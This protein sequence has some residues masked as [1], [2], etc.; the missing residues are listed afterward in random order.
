MKKAPAVFFALFVLSAMFAFPQGSFLKPGQHGLGVSGALSTN[1]NVSGVS[2]TFTY[3]LAGIFDFSVSLG[4]AAYGASSAVT[5]LKANSFVPEIRAYVLKQNSG[6]S[7][8][9]LSVS[10]GWARNNYSSPDLVEGGLDMWDKSLILGAAVHRDV[11]LSKKAYIQPFIGVTHASTTLKVKDTTTLL[12]LTTT[13]T[14][15]ALNLGV[16]LVYGLSDKAILFVQPGVSF[17]KNATT[18]SISAGLVY[19][20]TKPKITS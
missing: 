17:D 19:A 15:A 14:V 10:F 1:S 12:T 3:T 18:F 20:L 6:R 11:P 2:G 5:D 7:P 13:A 4:H 8:V 9:T 16:P